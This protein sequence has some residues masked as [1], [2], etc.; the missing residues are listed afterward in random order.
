MA[1]AA[2]RSQKSTIGRIGARDG[3]PETPARA[4]PDRGPRPMGWLATLLSRVRD[5]VGAA[6]DLEGWQVSEDEVR[7]D[8]EYGRE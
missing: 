5:P 1:T 7:A 2:V 4:R 8:L 3:A 6:W